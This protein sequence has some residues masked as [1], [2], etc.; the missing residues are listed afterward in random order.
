M[1]IAV[2][3]PFEASNFGAFLQAYALKS[4]L[5]SRGHQV[6]HV[7]YCSEK[8]SKRPFYRLRPGKQNLVR[9]REYW[10]DLN[11]GRQKYV[12]FKRDLEAFAVVEPSVAASM[13]AVILGSDEIWN[14]RNKIFQNPVFF[15]HGLENVLAYA[16]SVG[17]SNLDDYA[18]HDERLQD[19][20]RLRAVSARDERT[21]AF[22]E[23]VTSEAPPIVVDPTL[24][25]A[26]TPPENGATGACSREK[27]I[28]VYAYRPQHVPIEALRAFAR[29]RRLRLVSAGF[30]HDWCDESVNCSPLEFL[31]LV[32]GAEYVF[33]TTFHG[34]IFAILREKRFACHAR[35][36]KTIDL[37]KALNL[38]SRMIPPPRVPDTD[39]LARVLDS[40]TAYGPVLETIR[41]MRSVSEAY[42]D[43]ALLSIAAQHR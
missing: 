30:R 6:V 23:A 19:I 8:S 15:G 18:I 14:I 31:K 22:V 26:W 38:S 4:H 39:G 42:L 21:A 34:T 20:R 28:L 7:K 12:L 33:T 32:D 3:T 24:L 5:E 35:N 41:H 25:H 1:N 27:Y 13:D 16:P 29:T 40:G 2:I 10:S 11:F 17:A 9:P 36:P 43:Q 37:L